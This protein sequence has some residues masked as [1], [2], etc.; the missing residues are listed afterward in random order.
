VQKAN[1]VSRAHKAEKVSKVALGRKGLKAQKANNKAFRVQPVPVGPAKPG[2][3][4]ATG[5]HALKQDNV[6]R[7]PTATSNAAR[8]KSWYR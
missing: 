2:S 7:A 6:I 4:V 3:A 8:A 1:K 5:L